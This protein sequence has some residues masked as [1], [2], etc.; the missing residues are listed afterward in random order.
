MQEY[1]LVEDDQLAVLRDGD[2]VPNVGGYLGQYSVE[3]FVSEY[4]DTETDQM[5]L[6][7]S[8]AIFLYELGVSNPA[9]SAHDMQDLVMLVTMTS[10]GEPSCTGGIAGV[11]RIEFNMSGT[12]AVRYSAEALAKLGKT[13]DT[14]ADEIR[15]VV[16]KDETFTDYQEGAYGSGEHAQGEE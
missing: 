11:S 8:D 9:S 14:I 16:T 7:D 3:D 13:F 6:E 5:T 4:I 1:N 12:A 2:E 10:A 15:V